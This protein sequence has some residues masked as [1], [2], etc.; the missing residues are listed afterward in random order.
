[1]NK[2]DYLNQLENL[3]KKNHFEKNDIDDIIRDYAEFFEEGRRKGQNDAEISA[4]LGSPEIVVSQILEENSYKVS[5]AKIPEKKE[6]K[7]PKFPKLPKFNWKVREKSETSDKKTM[8]FNKN[9]A[10][11][12]TE[13]LVTIFKFLVLCVTLPCLIIAFGLIFC[14]I[15]F[16]LCVFAALLLL[17]I[18]GFFVSAF[19]AHFT[20]LTVTFFAILLFL[21]ILSGLICGTSLSLMFAA[22][23]WQLFAKVFQEILLWWKN[24][25]TQITNMEEKVYE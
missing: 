18:V 12:F 7:M 5:L 22:W 25:K 17:V 11:K 15:G 19:A 1:M 8:N 3:L 16:I 10:K 9:Y 23:L 13:I 21:T 4:K 24:S 2:L 14:L 6:F 20:T